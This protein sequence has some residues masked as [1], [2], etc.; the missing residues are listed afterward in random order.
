MR[1]RRY[2]GFHL[3]LGVMALGFLFY[4][5]LVKLLFPEGF[6]HC[7]MHD[8]MHLYCPFCGGTR[9][10]RALVLFRFSEALSL[11]SGVFVALLAFLVLDVRALWM[12]CKKREGELFPP[13]A[14]AF[15]VLWFFLY[16]V[17]KNAA[18]LS[19]VDVTGDL[20][21]FWQA[22]ASLALAVTFAILAL[23]ACL[24][25]FVATDFFISSFGGRVRLI[26]LVLFAVFTVAALALLY[27]AHM[28]WLLLPATLGFVGFLLAVRRKSSKNSCLSEKEMER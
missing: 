17:G 6:Y 8:V 2:I 21:P 7:F 24:S 22:R 4:A 12:L 16:G 10:A 26:A 11:N 18:L 14:G 19:G 25:F 9:A 15:A 13:K 27:G 3:G 5:F 20:L 1:W 28:L 23:V